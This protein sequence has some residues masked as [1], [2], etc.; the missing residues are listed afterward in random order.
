MHMKSGKALHN[1]ENI[2]LSTNITAK[3]LDET[4]KLIKQLFSYN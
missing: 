2:L 4:M 1:N 3:E